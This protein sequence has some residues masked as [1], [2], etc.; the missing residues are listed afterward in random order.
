[1]M[2]S[3]LSSWPRLSPVPPCF[4]T[5]RQGHVYLGQIVSLV[6]RKHQK[7]CIPRYSALTLERYSRTQLFS[8]IWSACNL[9]IVVNSIWGGLF[10]LPMHPPCLT[11]RNKIQRLYPYGDFHPRTFASLELFKIGVVFK[12]LR[13][14]L[15]TLFDRGL[16]KSVGDLVLDFS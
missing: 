1:M 12:L 2:I 6:G 8:I 9:A 5:T 13:I 16:P 10:N 11:H 7:A 15:A 3:I 4:I 14:S